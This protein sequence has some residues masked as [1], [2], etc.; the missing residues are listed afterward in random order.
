MKKILMWVAGAV[1]S[2]GLIASAN[3]AGTGTKEEATALI[4]KAIA[5]YK[6]NGKEKAYPQFNNKSGPFVD[7]D[8]YVYVVD[9]GG[10]VMAHGTNPKLIGKNLMQLKDADGKLFV[11]EIVEM[12]KAKKT[13]WVDYKWTNPVTKQIEQKTTLVEPVGDIGFAVGIYK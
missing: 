5:F 4:Q 3:A 12:I 7:R 13:G 8:L 11:M 9:T 1:F 6:T 10:H 2:A